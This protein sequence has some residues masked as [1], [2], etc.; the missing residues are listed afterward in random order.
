MC[1]VYKLAVFEIVK[2]LFYDSKVAQQKGGED[3]LMN[4]LR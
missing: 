3:S 2:M 4:P 1:R